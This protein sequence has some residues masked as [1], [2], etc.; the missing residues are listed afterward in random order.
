WLRYQGEY[1]NEFEPRISISINL[2]GPVLEFTDNGPGVDP[3][4]AEIIF[5][6]LV[7]SKPANQ[8]RGLGLYISREIASYHGWRLFM[9][10]TIGSV[11]K[12]R[13]NTFILD[14]D[15]SK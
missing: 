8:G 13:L 12:G 5:R 11:R 2:D 6:P 15:K 7:S 9:D 4:R 14:M 1:S 3:E 10:Q